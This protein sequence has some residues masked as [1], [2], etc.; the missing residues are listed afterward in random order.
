MTEY[1]TAHLSILNTNHPPLLFSYCVVQ[2]SFRCHRSRQGHRKLQTNKRLLVGGVLIVASKKD[3]AFWDTLINCESSSR[4]LRTEAKFHCYTEPLSKRRKFGAF[5]IASHDI[6]L[7]TFDVS[8]RIFPL[9][10]FCLYA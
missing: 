4:D 1:I 9:G 2:K 8:W 10:L 6:V 3:I 5:R 7:T